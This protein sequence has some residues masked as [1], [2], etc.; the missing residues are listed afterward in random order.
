M[1]ILVLLVLLAFIFM[2]F[3]DFDKYVII[4]AAW[5]LPLQ[6]LVVKQF[7]VMSCI[8]LVVFLLAIIKGKL[9]I[10]KYPFLFSSLLLGTS[11]LLSNVFG[12]FKHWGNCITMIS[13]EVL[14]PIV[15]W[16]CIKSKQGL[17]LFLK[18]SFVFLTVLILYGL[19]EEIIRD[20]PIIR[21]M[22]S[23]DAFSGSIGFTDEIRFGVKRMQSFLPLC[24]ALGCCCTMNFL[25]FGFVAQKKIGLS[26]KHVK[27]VP[28]LLAGLLLCT[29]LTGTRSVIAGFFCMLVYFVNRQ[30]IRSRKIQRF[31]P[32]LVVV[33]F[34]FIGFLDKIIGSFTDTQSVSGSN[35]DMREMQFNLALYFMGVSPI[36]GNGLAYTFEY[37]QAFF[38]DEILGA[39]SVWFPLMIEQGL[40]G[41]VSYLIYLLFPLLYALK[42]KMYVVVF[43]ILAFAVEKSL[44]S[45]PGIN[46]SYF[47]IYVIVFVKFNYYF[48]A[49]IKYKYETTTKRITK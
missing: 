14:F 46:I 37:V 4:A 30:T 33:L 41:V 35:S 28:Y 47:M 32:V 10:S 34:L 42:K 20:N 22:Q 18:H 7:S 43:C 3:V 26:Q 40:L 17:T 9:K 44:S 27:Y 15:V 11:I 8:S 39:E 24:G 1:S 12:V 6:M 38:P 49:N 19:F 29:L 48:L 23:S 16:H 36:F 21:L 13:L 25:L 2:L 45:L 31:I 5:I